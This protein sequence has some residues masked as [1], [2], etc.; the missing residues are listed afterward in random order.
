MLAS[1]RQAF[2]SP[3]WQSAWSRPSAPAEEVAALKRATP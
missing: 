2:G 1:W 3:A